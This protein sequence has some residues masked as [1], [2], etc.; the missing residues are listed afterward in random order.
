MERMLVVV[1]DTETKAYEGRTALLQLDAEGSIS[2]LAFAI[3]SKDKQGNVMVKQA[4]EPGPL[5]TLVGTS[6]GSLIGLLAGPVG[7]AVGA[8]AGLFAGM[9]TDLNNAR[10]SGDF[11]DEVSKQLQPG[12][13]A[14]VSQVQEDW[15]TPV[16][17]RMEALGGTVLRRALSD[18]TQAAN[19]Q[20]VNAMKADLAELKAEH[21][22]AQAERKAKL[23]QKINQLDAKIQARMEKAKQQRHAIEVQAK[24]K[25]DTLKRRAQELKAHVMAS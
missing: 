19:E 1:F 9:I 23:T 5:G 18:V 10:V 13:F 14:I 24:A 21:A 8:S 4:D 15:T 7:L 2:V 11:L 20:E 12:R 22:Q 6:A 16:D 17:V 25:A 3:I